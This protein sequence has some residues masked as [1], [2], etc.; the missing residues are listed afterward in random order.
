MSSYQDIYPSGLDTV[1]DAEYEVITEP[2]GIRSL[3]TPSRPST[4]SQSM[5]AVRQDRLM[6]QLSK[7]ALMTIGDISLIENRLNECAPQNMDL[8]RVILESYTQQAA[9]KIR[10]G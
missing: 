5:D 4:I 1:I 6:A 3:F 8:C 9:T 10:R 7:N 2:R